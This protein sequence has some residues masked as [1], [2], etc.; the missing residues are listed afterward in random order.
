MRRRGERGSSRPDKPL[1]RKRSPGMRL[2]IG[3]ECERVRLVRKRAIPDQCPRHEFG[4]VGR[5][6]GVVIFEALPQVGGCADIFLV[7]KGYATDDVDVPHAKVLAAKDLEWAFCMWS[8]SLSA[9]LRSHGIR[10]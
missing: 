2:Q 4:R 6:A 1:L 8:S 5:A 10:A 9:R 7:G 3:L